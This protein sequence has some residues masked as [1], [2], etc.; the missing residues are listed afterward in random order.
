MKNVLVC[1]KI[2]VTIMIHTSL[3]TS[4][5]EKPITLAEVLSSHSI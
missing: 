5:P 2:K 3:I 4:L 1:L